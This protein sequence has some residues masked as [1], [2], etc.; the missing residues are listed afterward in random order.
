MPEMKKSSFA[1][2]KIFDWQALKLSSRAELICC[3]LGVEKF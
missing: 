3:G 2:E 1:G